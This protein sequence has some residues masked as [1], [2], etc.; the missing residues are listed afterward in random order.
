MHTVILGK[1]I[2]NIY[3]VNFNWDAQNKY[4]TDK[5]TIEKN[6][7]IRG[8]KEICRYEGEPRYNSKT[9]TSDKWWD[10]TSYHKL[11]ISTK[12]EVVIEEEIFRADLN[13]MHLHTNKVI[14]AIDVSKEEAEGICYEQI[15]LFNEA[16]IKSNKIMKRYCNL[17]KLSYEDT[18]CI[19]LFKFLFPHSEYIIE[20]GVL[21]AK[22]VIDYKQEIEV[23]P[24]GIY[25]QEK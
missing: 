23:R 13:E 8:W 20:K 19:E 18:D 14:E 17:H 21:R 10:L 24:V 3:N 9:A 22:D 25:S 4:Y 12:E 16:M 1:M 11:N 6:T 2:K 5:P 7:I 15:K